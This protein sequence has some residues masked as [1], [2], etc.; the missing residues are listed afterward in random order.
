MINYVLSNF[1]AVLRFKSIRHVMGHTARFWKLEAAPVPLL[2]HFLLLPS[3]VTVSLWYYANYPTSNSLLIAH[4]VTIPCI[5]PLLQAHL[6]RSM[7][8]I[9]ASLWVL[10]LN[11][12]ACV[13]IGEWFPNTCLRQFLDTYHMTDSFYCPFIPEETVFTQPPPDFRI[14]SDGSPAINIA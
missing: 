12:Y 2:L 10:F 8:L 7:L 13:W 6:L 3:T 9:L 5:S 4:E 14:P 11:P 1:F